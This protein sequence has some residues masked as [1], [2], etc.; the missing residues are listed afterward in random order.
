VPTHASDDPVTRDD[1]ADFF[2]AAER[3][4]PQ[5][6]L[7]GTELEKFGVVAADRNA[8]L[9]PVSHDR[10]I[11]PVL[12]A[13]VE[14]HGWT[15]GLDQGEHH[16]VV[17]LSRDGA[18]ITL[19]PGGQLELSGK[20]LPDVHQTCA[21]FTEHYRELHDVS[22]PL[23][24]TWLAAGFHPWATREEINWMPKGRYRVMRDYLPTRG[25]RGLDMML[26]TCT[27]QA[28]FDYASEQQC[29]E[30][31]RLAAVIAPVVTAMFANSPYQEGRRTGLQSTRIRIWTDVD[32]DRCGVPDFFFEPNFSY[33]RYI[34]WVLDVPMFFVK[35]DGI[36]HA[37]HIPF[38]TFLEHGFDAPD[39]RHH[40]ATQTDWV[41]HLS[42]VFPEVRIKP[43]VEFRSADSVGSKYVCALPALLKGILYD[44][45]ATQATWDRF[46][47]LDTAARSNLW[48]VA[49]AQG[50]HDPGVRDLARVLLDF[51]RAAL[52]SMDVRDAKGRTEARFLDQLEP[53]VDQ[54]RSPG[55][56]A[57]DMLGDAP[58]RSPRAQH[59]FV[60]AFHFAGAFG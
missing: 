5:T 1:L 39:G 2:T 30:R 24:V 13:L 43:Y 33:E 51:A 56:D 19:E 53:L 9:E 6:H 28:N 3:P 16:E 18:S 4:D 49:S 23:G 58:G 60:R 17:E 47:G 7:I 41:L 35:R 29:G 45:D 26:R 34:D 31:V 11:V 38:R 12:A 14:H 10:H 32:P 46:S 27:V 59:D 21:E 48:Q 8:P 57:V 55:D 50:L 15:V 36:Y 20:P 37:H 52:D 40:R 44:A 25:G 54:G 22:E 42:T